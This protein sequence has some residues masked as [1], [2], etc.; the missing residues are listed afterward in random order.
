M[1]GGKW[2]VVGVKWHR[3]FACSRLALRSFRYSR[4]KMIELRISSLVCRGSGGVGVVVVIRVVV[5]VEVGD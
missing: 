3:S 2:L 4:A 5:G 1:V